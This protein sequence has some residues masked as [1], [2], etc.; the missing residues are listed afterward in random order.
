MEKDNRV[1]LLAP[2]GSPAA[3]YGAVNAGADAVYLGGDKF[4]ARAYAE[5]FTQEELVAC[6]Q[7][8]RL[9]G[10]KVYLT[11]NTLLKEEEV[12]RLVDYLAPFYQAGLD[13]VIVQDM[14]VLRVIRNNFPEL[15]IHAST[16]M[17]ICNIY[18]T[19]LLKEMGVKRIVPARELSLKE[20]IRIKEQV[21]IELETFI[22]GAMCYCYSGQ[23]LFSSI[24]GGRSGNRGRCAQPCRLPYGVRF[25]SVPEDLKDVLGDF[26]G[27]SENSKDSSGDFKGISENLKDTSRES[28]RSKT[29][30]GRRDDFY[31]LSLKDMCT[32][33]HI[34]AL[35]EAGIDSFKIEGRMKKPEYA[36][37][38]TAI[39]RKY[40]EY[41]YKLRNEL[42]VKKARKGYKVETEDIK[43]L[44]SLYIRSQVQD[45]YYFRHNGREMITM[46]NPAYS[47]TDEAVLDK[48][49]TN[50]LS[51]RKKLDVEIEA[52]FLTGKPARVILR[53]GCVAGEAE[54]ETVQTAS[55]QP[56]TEENLRKQL[57]K[58]GDTHFIAKKIHL[59]ISN[60]AFYPLKQINELRRTAAQALELSLL[61]RN[62]NRL[63]RSTN[64]PST[65]NDR[66]NKSMP[67]LNRYSSERDG[68]YYD[69]GWTLSVQTL[70]QMKELA[71]FQAEAPDIVIRRVYVDGDM[72]ISSKKDVLQICRHLKNNC[73]CQIL[74][75]LPYVLRLD[76]EKYL[77]ELT[78]QTNASSLD[79]LFDGFLIRS[80]DGIG[81]FM[82]KKKHGILRGDACLYTWNRQAVLQLS[83]LLDGFCIPFE[84]NAYEQACLLKKHY[85]WEKIV[86]ARIPMMITANCVLKTTE[87]CMRGNDGCIQL[88]DRY[89][90]RFPVMRNC[91]HCTNIIYNSVPLSL[92][93]E[94]SSLRGL[95]DLR[96]DFTV[97]TAEETRSVL[98][99]FLRNREFVGQYT[100][101]HER[102]GVV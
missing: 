36:A 98:N 25:E 22:H 92:H 83:E 73:S 101:G 91:M 37:G 82:G 44:S 14:G 5:N 38:V 76:D 87:G 72:L 20:L 66:P 79:G 74:I 24:L 1:E 89:N 80:F 64:I 29:I 88:I 39:Y 102:R 48:I 77:E 9:F 30:G 16:Q 62:N 93:S 49:R 81:F 33:E 70:Q 67:D 26:K 95:C 52:E 40:I 61:C 59:K 21:D 3:F 55:K 11:V 4:G 60:E 23:C 94:V 18:G 13:A 15:A 19:R 86:Y 68:F 28:R 42:G 69:K 2:A 53:Q 75:A 43:L 10:V 56:I 54:G 85:P 41:Y 50:Y 47:G 100:T 45:G 27:I 17:T 96:L 51:D 35:I 97:E 58:L 65:Q 8:G 32:I 6:I 12:E 46:K 34:P 84:L 99:T 78:E 57:N 90:K 7:Y 63:V 71:I 31:P